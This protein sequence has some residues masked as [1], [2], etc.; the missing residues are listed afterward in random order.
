[1]SERTDILSN[2]ILLSVRETLFSMQDLSYRDFHAK[3]IPTVSPERIIGV[4][5]PALRKYA[6]EFS[7]TS[8][9][10]VFLEL[11][12]HQYYE[13]NNLHAFLIE[14]LPDFQ[15]TIRA[16]DRFLPYVD[17]WATC[18]MMAPKIFK[19]NRPALFIKAKE[20]ISSGDLYTVRYGIKVLMDHFL[21][22]DFTTEC[23]E[24][25]SSVRSEEY[26]IRMMIAWYFATALAKRREET[27][28]YIRDRRLP[29]WIH[30]KAIQKAVESNRISKEEKTILRA[31]KIAKEKDV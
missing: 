14:K 23:L 8:D 12:P 31:L 2:E 10:G 16:L 1:M 21:D 19:K 13:E 29:V 9:A 7:R 3:L 5:T 30:N 20:W 22:E 15:Q 17:N 6:V 24:I 18:D 26:Y 27:F 28:P 25:V 11:L 4:R